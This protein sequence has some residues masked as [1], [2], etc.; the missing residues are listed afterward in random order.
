MDGIF[1]SVHTCPA[2]ITLLWGRSLS[3][4][5]SQ[6]DGQQW[7]GI[8]GKKQKNRFAV[9]GLAHLLSA[10]ASNAVLFWHVFPIETQGSYWQE[11]CWSRPLAFQSSHKSFFLWAPK[12][13]F[14]SVSIPLSNYSRSSTTSLIIWRTTVSWSWFFQ[15]LKE[16]LSTQLCPIYI[17]KIKNLFLI[18]SA[19]SALNTTEVWRGAVEVFFFRVNTP[20]RYSGDPCKGWAI[21][22]CEWKQNVATG[23][24]LE[25]P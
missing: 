7:H 14:H 11:E 2:R 21:K 8:F 3:L 16:T 24:L 12:G 19:T 10:A 5:P 20:E 22:T 25:C 23:M 1:L 15:L 17:H 18:T 6:H 4:L 13:Q 9:S